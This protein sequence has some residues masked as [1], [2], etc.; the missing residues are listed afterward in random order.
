MEITTLNISGFRSLRQ[1]TWLPGRLNVLIG[2]NGS[3]KTNLLRA[4]ALLKQAASGNLEQAVVHSGGLTQ[5]CWDGKFKEGIRWHVESKGK[6]LPGD[7]ANSRKLSYHLGM[8]YAGYPSDGLGYSIGNELLA[9]YAR[10]DSGEEKNALKYLDRGPRHAAF[11]DSSQNKLTAPEERIKG[12]ETLLSQVGGLF[13]APETASFYAFL[14]SLGIYHEL[15]VNDDA[16]VRRAAV[17]RRETQLR[18]D[19]QNLIAVLH[20]LYSTNRG[21]KADL[22]ATMRA[23]FGR[24]FDEIEFPPAE[25][26]RVQMRLHWRPLKSS[27]STSE[28]SEGTLRLL[29]L[30]AVLSNPGRGDF[31]AIDEPE[32][33]LHPGMFPIIADLA[34]EAAE[35]SQIVFTTH[36]PQFLDAL[37]SKSPVTTVTELIDGATQLRNLDAEDLSRWMK[38]YTLG[39]LFKSGELEALP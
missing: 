28:L 29:M 33:Y 5:I 11:F 38:K 10:V 7:D 1:V 21:F 6:F 2:P 22:S 32:T 14:T 4:L 16:E 26:Q 36:S 24:D 12:T 30:I 15:I 17:T 19:G 9:D 34:A 3:G 25:D 39:E 23:A 35:T 37:G 8:H 31:I 27:H 20:T 13:S 18:E